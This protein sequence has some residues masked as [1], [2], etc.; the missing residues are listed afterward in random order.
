MYSSDTRPLTVLNK[1][2]EM[3]KAAMQGILAGTPLADLDGNGMW[4]AIARDSISAADA[5]IAALEKTPAP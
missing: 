3:A 5:L 4:E 2:E 1:R